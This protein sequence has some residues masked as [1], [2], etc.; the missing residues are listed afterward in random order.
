[1]DFSNMKILGHTREL[2]ADINE[3]R[4]TNPCNDIYPKVPYE[5][6]QGM[7]ATKLVIK[8]LPVCLTF[9]SLSAL[10]KNYWFLFCVIL[11]S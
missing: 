2:K 7:I 9:N 6:W 11:K 8:Q 3:K 10:P 1:M 4:M 5:I